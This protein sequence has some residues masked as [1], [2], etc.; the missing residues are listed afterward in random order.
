MRFRAFDGD[1]RSPRLILIPGRFASP[2]SEFFQL[3]I[4]PEIYT[5]RQRPMLEFLARYRIRK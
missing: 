2:E 3:F 1:H 5:L 4:S